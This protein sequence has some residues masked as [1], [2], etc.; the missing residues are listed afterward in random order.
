MRNCPMGDSALLPGEYP[1]GAESIACSCPSK[2]RTPEG[3]STIRRKDEKSKICL[4]DGTAE[5]NIDSSPG[6]IA[7]SARGGLAPRIVLSFVES[8]CYSDCSCWNCP[9]AQLDQWNFLL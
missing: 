7:K 5:L 1:G 4:P 8:E 9:A 3:S 2:G 6:N